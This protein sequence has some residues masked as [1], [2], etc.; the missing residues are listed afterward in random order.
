MVQFTFYQNDRKCTWR[1]KD[2]FYL[3]HIEDQ[4]IQLDKHNYH[5]YN[6]HRLNIDIVLKKEVIKRRYNSKIEVVKGHC[7][8]YH[9]KID[10]SS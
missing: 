2:I 10:L 9:R 7:I 8:V 4:Q 6:D 1:N 3:F 5:R